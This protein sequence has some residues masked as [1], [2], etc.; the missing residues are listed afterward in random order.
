MVKVGFVF[1]FDDLSWSGGINYFKNLISAI[2][3]IKDR[4]IEVII[5]TGIKKGG[6]IPIDF[7]K[8][9]LVRYAFFDQKSISWYLRYTFKK[10]FDFDFFLEYACKKNNINVISH[11]G[12]IGRYSKISCIGNIFD[13]QHKYMPELFGNYEILSRN[14]QFEKLI[15]FCD[16]VI[17]SS[18]ASKMDYMKF[19]SIYSK[20]VQVLS[21][22][23]IYFNLEESKDEETIFRNRYSL[24]NKYFYLPNQFWKHKNHIVVLKA[25]NYL[26]KHGKNIFIVSSGKTIDYRDPLYFSKITQY[27]SDNLLDKNFIILGN[28][29]I[30]DVQ[31][32]LKYSIA[33]INPSLFEGWSTS[34]EESKIHDKQIILS[35]IPVHIEQSPERGY[36]F[37]PIDYI[38][39]AN[40]LCELNDNYNVFYENL[41]YDLAKKTAL[42]KISKYGFDFQEI[43]FNTIKE[44]NKC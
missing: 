26:S 10:I 36:F 40:I 32:I 17:V 28:I 4:K 13:F 37:D 2:Y 9:K 33:V 27:I 21:F 42:D 20:K 31:L 22:V 8:I 44:K 25:L 30:K 24:P 5:L 11:S 35:S 43:V 7:P 41:K 12:Y 23:S 3:C 15:K 38:Q 34:V 14:N 1:Y 16:T 29:P 18:L 19:Y 6:E 39:L